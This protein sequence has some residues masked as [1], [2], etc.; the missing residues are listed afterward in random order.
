MPDKPSL[1][2]FVVESPIAYKSFPLAPA[3]GEP[4]DVAQRP[5]EAMLSPADRFHRLSG[6]S[7]S[8]TAWDSRCPTKLWSNSRKD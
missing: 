1:G 5:R 6:Q 4:K 8:F 2:R 3:Q 7:G